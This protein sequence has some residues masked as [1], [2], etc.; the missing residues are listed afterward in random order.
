MD[1]QTRDESPRGNTKVTAEQWLDAAEAVLIRDG[2]AQ[3]KVL[4]LSE[5]LGVS[6]SSFY[7]YFKS[8]RD[9]LDRLL[10]RWQGKN[11][12]AVLDHAA[13]EA[14]KIT[15]SVMHLFEC[16]ID[17]AKFDPRL[18]FAVREWARRAP[19]VRAELDRADTARVSA[20]QEMFIRHGFAPDEAFV[21]ARIVY[22]MQI[23]YYA[24]VETEPLE[25]RIAQLE[26]YLFA[27]TGEVPDADE[28]HAFVARSRQTLAKS[29]EKNASF[30][31]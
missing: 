3:V 17:P 28:M 22:F 30:T 16:F 11:T 25:T 4:P 31:T 5:A 12:Q 1:G 15:G 14:S 24:L 10:A 9:L 13:R 8:R 26:S 20:I 7:W 19:E 27:F 6:R 29:A 21:R 2:V 18:D 23:G